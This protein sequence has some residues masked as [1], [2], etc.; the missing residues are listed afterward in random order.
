MKRYIFK[1]VFFFTVIAFAGCVKEPASIFERDSAERLNDFV[2]KARE[3]LK[4]QKQ[5][6]MIKYYPSSDLEFGGYTVFANFT[7]DNEATL[8]SDIDDSRINSYYSVIAESGPILT[9]NTYNPIIHFF[10]EPGGDS[11]IGAVDSGLKGDFEFIILSIE[12][13]KIVLKGKKSGNTIEMT[14]VPAT[15]FNA[16]ADSYY[17]AAGA[18]FE[19]T[20]FELETATGRTELALSYNTFQNAADA[21]SELM[22]FR[23]VP[24]GLDFYKEYELAGAKFKSLSYVPAGAGYP[25][26][27]YTNA[28]KTFKIVPVDQPL[29]SWFLANNWALTYSGVG[30]FGIPYWNASRTGLTNAGFTLTSVNLGVYSNARALYFALNNNA[31]RGGVTYTMAPVSGT[32]DEISLTFG[33]TFAPGAVGGFGNPHW[34]AGLNFLSTPFAGKTFKITSTVPQQPNEML[35]TDK[36]NANNTFKL[37]RGTVTDPFN[38]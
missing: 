5:G 1:L 6:W 21:N 14:A 23:I 31:I 32:K 34:S 38:K 22:S 9:F 10:S 18:F 36:S 29:N 8:T 20:N 30:P 37:I 25:Y 11:G 13:G 7:S 28:A 35:L 12:D 26:G 4:A 19:F 16:T 2:V 3:T 17:D 15:G 33:G 24:A 27:Y